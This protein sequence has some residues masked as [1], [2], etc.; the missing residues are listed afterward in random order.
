M[1]AE[2]A[3]P[4]DDARSWLLVPA[5]RPELF[6]AAA[7]SDADAVVL[8]IEDAVDPARK[9]AARAD[10]IAWLA[11]GNRAWVRINERG[12]DFWADDVRELRG[13]PGLLGVVLAKAEAGGDIEQTVRELGGVPVIALIESALGLEEAAGIARCGAFRLAFGSGDFRRDTGMWASRDAM[14][15]ARSRLTVASRAAGLPGPIDGPTTDES[16]RTLREQAE[17]TIEFG[18]TGKLCLRAEQAAVVNEVICPQRSD[19]QW[20]QRFLA[21]FDAAGGVVRDGSDPPRLGRARK[22]LRLAAVF[23][24]IPVEGGGPGAQG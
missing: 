12:S 16:L 21:E 24:L 10:V 3:V 14:A 4:A 18:M 23:G 5:S 8:D 15:Y 6:D 17:W 22:I 11:A 9:D 1:S 19:I 20:A 2:H 13:S 7:A